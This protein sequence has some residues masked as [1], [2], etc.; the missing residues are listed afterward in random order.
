MAAFLRC[1]MEPV[2]VPPSKQSPLGLRSW[3]RDVGSAVAITVAP[4]PFPQ[5]LSRGNGQ[6]VLLVP[7]FLTGDWSMTRLAAFLRSLGYHVVLP[8]IV[9]NLG[10]T[11]KSLAKL[12]AL[13]L[14][15]AANQKIFVIGQSL[16]GVFARTLARRYP[17]HTLGVVT[18]CTPIRFPVVTPLEPFVRALS[19][20][21]D[22]AWVAQRGDVARALDVPVAAIYSERDGIVDWRQ[23]LDNSASCE[24]I[25]IDGPHT[26]MGSIEAA[27]IAIANALA[28]MNGISAM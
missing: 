18:L 16:G 20:L 24:N 17:E 7:G 3:L 5:N 9:L 19:P 27:Q 22:P 8:G 23:C 1:D 26:T 28:R 10:P 13:F 15:L 4:P 14:R 12:D 21:H 6:T 25:R 11:A 2:A